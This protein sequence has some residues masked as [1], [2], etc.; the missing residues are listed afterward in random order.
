MHEYPGFLNQEQVT[1]IV[2]HISSHDQ[3]KHG[4]SWG[5]AG[6]VNQSGS[7]SDNN[8]PGIVYDMTQQLIDYNDIQP[9]IPDMLVNPLL[10]QSNM[11]IQKLNQHAG[12]ELNQR[13]KQLHRIRYNILFNSLVDGYHLPHVDDRTL[14]ESNQPV[15][16]GIIHLYGDG[17][18][19]LFDKKWSGEIDT[20]VSESECVKVQFEPGKLT[21][22]D[23]RY[24]HSS[25]SPKKHNWRLV[26]N[27]NLT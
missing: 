2:G 20:D 8:V 7:T 13:F 11:I 10:D 19:Y 4:I 18:T 1:R 21:L 26:I 12:D 24:Y 23:G 3:L 6:G 25:S 5:F 27:L 22:F 16:I 9:P 14:C 17:D 15:W